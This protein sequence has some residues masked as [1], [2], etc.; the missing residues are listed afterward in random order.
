MKIGGFR[1]KQNFKELIQIPCQ[2]AFVGQNSFLFI[3]N[4]VMKSLRYVGL[5]IS[6][7]VFKLKSWVTHI[8][9]SFSGIPR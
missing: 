8:I 9:S 4:W 2:Y 5:F 3:P 7:E 1:R 6:L